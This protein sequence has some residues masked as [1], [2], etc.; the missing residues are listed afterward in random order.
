MMESAVGA[1]PEMRLQRTELVALGSAALLVV[2]L[3]L[4]WFTLTDEPQLRQQ[5]D[6][7]IC[8]AGNYECSG[9]ETFPINRWLFLAAAAAPVILTYFILTSQRGQYPTGEFT[10]TVGLAVIV[11]V[12]FN[13]IIQKPGTGVQ[14]GIGLSYGYFLAILAGVIMAGAGALRSLESGGGATRKPPATF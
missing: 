10:M 8:G 4:P 7:W 3:F 13:G 1:Q 11:L 5:Q 14:F 9:W 12:G 2:S 6:A